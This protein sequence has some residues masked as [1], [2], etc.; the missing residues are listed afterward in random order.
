MGDALR[1]VPA[2]SPL[3]ELQYREGAAAV[4]EDEQLMTRSMEIRAS[5]IDEEARSVEVNMATE[6]R[7]AVLDRTTFEIIDEVLLMSGV[8]HPARMPLLREHLRGLDYLL[9]SMRSIRV[10]KNRLVG[11]AFFAKD[12]QALRVWENVRDEHIDSVSIGY[13]VLRSVVIEPGQSAVV[14]GKEFKAGRE[15]R[16]RVATKWVPR[17]TSVVVF[18]ADPNAKVRESARRQGG[19]TSMDLESLLALFPEHEA[20]VRKMHGEGKDASAIRKAVREVELEAAARDWQARAQQDDQRR[21]QQQ[22]QQQSQGDEDG[23]ALERARVLDIQQLCGDAHQDVAREAIKDG[24]P[25]ERVTRRLLELER[26]SR[27]APVTAGARIEVS[28]ERALA[29]REDLVTGITYQRGDELANTRQREAV[30]RFGSIGLKDLGRL[31]LRHEHIEEPIGDD[32][33]VF[34]RALSTSSFPE[35][36]ANSATKNLHRGYNENPGTLSIWAGEREVADFKTYSELRLSEFASMV[37]VG[38]AGELEHG[39]LTESKESYSADTYGKLFS[40]TRKTWIND[41][42][43]AL[44]RVPMKLGMAARRNIDDLGYDLLTSASGVGPTMNEDSQALFSASHAQSNYQ[45]G[46]GTALQ[47][48]SVVTA[49]T[50]LRKIK[51]PGGNEF[52][53]LRPRWMLLPPELEFT[54]MKLMRSVELKGDTDG[55]SLNV[56]RG[57]ARPIVEPRL[58]GKTNGTTAWWLLADRMDAETIVIVY[59]RG[60]RQPTLERKDPADILGIGWRIYHDIGVAAIDWRGGV[61]SK[62]A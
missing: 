46:A 36:L 1:I 50:L 8:D 13:Y 62:G 51:G 47:E 38:E 39:G 40:L 9:G 45:T 54:G 6:T 3:E 32:V 53:N 59:L 48:S 30:E 5:T 56:L 26:E 31:C 60:N 19:H 10:E 17:E 24:W 34:K 20:L 15:R 42:L 55:P 49:V 14:A 43:G 44:R 7:A 58:S 18:G 35:I 52:L 22:Q 57:L 61:R 11:R 37:K 16:L 27:A 4:A 2:W 33:L 28:E 12:E 25:V 41:D 29:F 21:A 23:A